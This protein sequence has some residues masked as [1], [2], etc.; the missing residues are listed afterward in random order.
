MPDLLL[1]FSIHLEQTYHAGGWTEHGPLFHRWLPDG[2]RDAIEVSTCENDVRLRVWFERRGYVDRGFITYDRGRREVD[3][4]IMARQGKLDAGPLLGSL[5]VRSLPERE[6]EAL[7]KGKPYVALGKKVARLLVPPIRRFVKV[8][9]T[10]YGQYWIREVK[11]WDSRSE[12]LGSYCSYLGLAW[13]LD[14]GKTWSPFRPNILRASITAGGVDFSQYLT[15]LDWKQISD[16]SRKGDEPLLPAVLLAKTNE[17]LREGN[18]RYALV[19]GVSALELALHH[20]IEQNLRADKKLSSSMS[21]FWQLPLRTQVVA[22]AA[23]VVAISREDLK[24]TLAAIE[25]RNAAV[26]EGR[27]PSGNTK[28]ELLGLMRTVATLLGAASFK[29][30]D[31]YP[32]GNLLYP[33]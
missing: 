24:N 12:S 17:L 1:K 32:S 15:Q 21:T 26:H 4:A 7:R 30:P 28:L 31:F 13:S 22:V 16:I 29:F 11:K 25:S 5:L 20:F 23:S 10:N 3:T 2:E 14:D 9:R 19:E 18:L 6:V 33:P 27:A 8:L